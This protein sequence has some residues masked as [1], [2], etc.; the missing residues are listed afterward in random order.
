MSLVL[1]LLISARSF[2]YVPEEGNIYAIAG[3]VLTKPQFRTSRPGVSSPYFV[4][5]SLLVQGDISDRGSLEISMLHMDRVFYVDHGVNFLEEQSEYFHISMGYRRWLTHY[6]S[7]GLAFYSAYS[8]G[9]PQVVTSSLQPGAEIT[10]SARDKTEY[11][12]DLSAQAEI[13]SKDHL[14]LILDARYSR[15]VTPK[16]NESGDIYAYILGLRYFIQEKQVIEK[17]KTAL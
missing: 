12:F 14:A 7:V 9:T 15:S 10:S 5:Q 1:I 13:W 8:M 3:P 4:G 16:D 2:A 17:P 6:V 11:G